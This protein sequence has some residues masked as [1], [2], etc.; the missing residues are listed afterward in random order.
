MVQ[1]INRQTSKQEKRSLLPE[2]NVRTSNYKQTKEVTDRRERQK[3]KRTKWYYLYLLLIT[4][5][6]RPWSDV[7]K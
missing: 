6:C 4:P 3:N 5:L 1:L 2:L 7:S